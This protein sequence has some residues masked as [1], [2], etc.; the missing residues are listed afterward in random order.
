[1]SGTST[2]RTSP[3][4]AAPLQ[5]EAE[6]DSPAAN[7]TSLSST[8]TA[9]AAAHGTIR[10]EDLGEP[11]QRLLRSIKGDV[12]DEDMALLEYVAVKDM[13]KIYSEMATDRHAEEIWDELRAALQARKEKMARREVELAAKQRALEEEQA[14][15]AAR[16]QQQLEEEEQERI[17]AEDARVRRREERRRRKAEKAAAAAAEEEAA[18]AAA[19]AAAE[20]AAEEAAAAAAEAERLKRAEKKRKRREAR[21]RELQE[22]QDALAAERAKH[23][24]KKQQK[25]LNQKKDWSEYVQNHPLEYPQETEGGSQM[26]AVIA[27]KEL[28]H[29]LNAPPVA[30]EKLL[31]RTYTPMCPSCGSR[32]DHPPLEWNC[33]VCFKRYNKVVKVWQ[34]DDDTTTCMMCKEPIGWWSRHHCRNCGRLVCANCSEKRAIIQD[35]GYDAPVRVCFDCARLRLK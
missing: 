32:F 35:L 26:P 31:H 11:V 9:A 30:S 10:F 7:T 24:A 22:E 4:P 29:T 18:E 8:T 16:L 13:A 20:E 2:P 1:M 34:P 5:Q 33:P 25:S 3:P 14:A 12:S 28:Q 19:A 6:N 21:A 23:E 17:A 15:E 27:Q